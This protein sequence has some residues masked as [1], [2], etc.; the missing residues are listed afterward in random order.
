MQQGVLNDSGLRKPTSDLYRSYAF[1]INLDKGFG[2]GK[3]FHKDIIAMPPYKPA[4]TQYTCGKNIL[5][6]CLF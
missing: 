2:G 3:T 5:A 1:F 4:A 6:N